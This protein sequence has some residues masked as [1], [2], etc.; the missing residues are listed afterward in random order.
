MSTSTKGTV[1]AVAVLAVALGVAIVAA[2][3]QAPTAPGQAPAPAQAQAPA[4]PAEAKP[5]LAE[6][7]Y[8][9]IQVLKGIPADQ[10]E[11]AMDFI[12]ASLGVQ[13]EHCH[14]QGAP[15]KDDK[16]Q[17]RTA[18]KMI[19]MM[20][21]I[22]KESFEG[23]RQVT[24]FSCHR[25]AS[26]PVAVPLVSDGTPR[27]EAPRPPAPGGPNAPRPPAAD[28]ILPKYTEAVGGAEAIQK[29]TSRIQRGNLIFGG[30]QVPVEVFAKAPDKR[31]AVAHLP[32]GGENITAYDGQTG[33]LGTTGQPPRVMTE[34]QTAAI[35]LDSDFYFAAHANQIL[36]GLRPGR[37]EKINDHETYVLTGRIA[38][39]PPVRL[40][41][42]QET[43]L[44]VRQ[45]RFLE[46]PLGRLPT[47]IDYDDYRSVDGVKI[48]FR[49]TLARP[50]GLFTIQIDKVEQNVP[51]DDSKFAPPGASPATPPNPPS[52]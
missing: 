26:D 12:A 23:R 3:A 6:E 33:W 2:R 35:K 47:Q 25:G 27:P 7:V 46:T 37:P 16:N 52:N 11:P 30:R 42:D 24:C 44:L 41:F 38:G 5:K 8:K 14:V 22:N 32:N 1:L 31:A 29:V 17:K 28:Q 51:I 19:E 43:G 39:Q 36:T 48:P 20:N 49:W 40:Y 18:R 4:Q 21:A 45:V 34:A 50:N 15:E 10:L 13:C 9:N